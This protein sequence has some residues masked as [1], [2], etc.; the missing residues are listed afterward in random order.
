MRFSL[1]LMSLVTALAC[2]LLTGV[3]SPQPAT[4]PVSNA[5]FEQVD[6][7]TG[8]PLDWTPWSQE[9]LCAYTLAT[10]HSGVAAAM[11]TDTDGTMSQGLRCKPIP[12]EPGKTYEASCWLNISELK[13]GGFALYL[14]YWCGTE[15]VQNVAVSCTEAGV[16]KQLQVAAPAPPNATTAT[17][18]IYGAS[19][20]VGTAYFDDVVLTPQP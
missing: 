6:P 3:A 12:I 10:A 14:E 11:I 16:W 17:V 18:I 2:G 20:A 7:K 13:A 4:I 19:A 5:G 1:P 9:N 15:R 8:L